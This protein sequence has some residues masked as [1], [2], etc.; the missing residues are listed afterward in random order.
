MSDEPHREA[1]VTGFHRLLARLDRDPVRAEAEFKRLRG[2]LTRFFDWRGAPH[3]DDG[4]D[5][6]LSR[7]AARLEEGVEVL[8]VAGFAHGIAKLVFREVARARERETSLDEERVAAQRGDG[9]GPTEQ[10]AKRLDDCLAR[11]SS[12]ERDLVL[13]YYAGGA[14]QAKIERRRALALRSGLSGSALRSR[15]QR[16]RDRLEDCVRSK[17][18]LGGRKP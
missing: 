12:P 11:F 2:A 15:V 1:E 4:A 18:D 14:G 10:I 9:S 8:D 3:P 13:S 6:T 16:L 5:E 17:E 7:L